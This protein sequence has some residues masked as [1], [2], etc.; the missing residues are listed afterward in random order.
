MLMTAKIIIKSLTSTFLWLTKR[1]N[2]LI[3]Y[4]FE[5]LQLKVCIARTCFTN[6]QWFDMT[7]NTIQKINISITCIKEFIKLPKFN[8]L[9]Y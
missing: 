6:I 5:D 1:I 4:L 3:N 7:T 8:G 2:Y 9:T